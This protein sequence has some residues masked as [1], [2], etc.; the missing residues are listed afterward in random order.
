[1]AALVDVKHLVK[2]FPVLM[3]RARE[4]GTWQQLSLT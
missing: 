3:P 2:H 4:A 1:M